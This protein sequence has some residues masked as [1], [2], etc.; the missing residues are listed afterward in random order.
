MGVRERLL[1]YIQFKQMSIRRFQDSIGVSNAYVKNINKSVG[2]DIKRRI[3]NL[4]PEL[5]LDWVETGNGTMIKEQKEDSPIESNYIYVIPTSAQAGSLSGFT[6][7]IQERDCEKMISP[8]NN[9]DYAL[10]VTGNSMSPEFPNGS[11]VIVKKINEKAFIDWGRTYVLD[12]CNGVVIKN[13]FPGSEENS[14]TCVSINK[15]F[16][17]YEIKMSDIYGWYRVLMC[18]SLK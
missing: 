15:D 14:V 4:Y 5:N 16:P 10:T 8:I 1:D 6:Q 13:V 9:A 17:N 7:S 12:T 11:K 2:S 3:E 18:L